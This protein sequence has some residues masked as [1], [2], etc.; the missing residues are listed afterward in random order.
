MFLGWTLMSFF[1][2]WEGLKCHFILISFEGLWAWE[3]EEWKEGRTE[4][5]EGPF[6]AT[7]HWLRCALSEEG[8][9]G[10]MEK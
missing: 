5:R 4:K 10:Q 2:V 8:N 1:R 9:V 6:E 7:A 3:R